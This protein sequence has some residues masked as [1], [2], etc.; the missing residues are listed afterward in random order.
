MC[1]GSHSRRPRAAR[2]NRT[3]EMAQCEAPGGALGG[4][5]IPPRRA[6]RRQ[7]LAHGAHAVV[8]GTMDMRASRLREHT[9]WGIA[10]PPLTPWAG[11]AP[12]PE[13]ERASERASERGGVMIVESVKLK[14]ASFPIPTQARPLAAGAH[15]GT[16]VVRSTGAGGNVVFTAA[17]PCSGPRCR[18]SPTR[19]PH[20][21][22]RLAPR[23]RSGPPIRAVQHRSR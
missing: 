9:R 16:R 22:R 7:A 3:G 18:R 14:R 21:E 10:G 20:A 13:S 15:E 19:S 6:A 4:G 11:R 5:G 2:G 8:R 12:D 23:R 1:S 17:H